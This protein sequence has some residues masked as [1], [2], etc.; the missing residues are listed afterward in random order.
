MLYRGFG[1]KKCGEEGAE[2]KKIFSSTLL[3]QLFPTSTSRLDTWQ[4]KKNSLR[5]KKDFKNGCV[6][7]ESKKL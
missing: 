4:I 3:I 5:Q 7:E 6:P 2:E 1:T